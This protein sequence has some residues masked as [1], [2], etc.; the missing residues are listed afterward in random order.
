MKKS[1]VL[2]V[3]VCCGVILCG[4]D[5]K[6]NTDV[7]DISA[8][9]SA[10]ENFAAETSVTEDSVDTGSKITMEDAEQTAF[11]DAG[12]SE[13]DVTHLKVNHDT[14][15]NVFKVEFFDASNEYKYEISSVAGDIISKSI[16]PRLENA[17]PETTATVS[18]PETHPLETTTVQPAVTESTT[19]Q[20]AATTSA[21]AKATAA[22][23]ANSNIN[24]DKA[25]EIAF[26]DAGVSESD[27]EYINAKPD[28]DDGRDVFD[29]EF[30]ADGVEYDYEIDAESG[31]ILS[32]DKDA[33]N[34]KIP[35]KTEKAASG[36]ITEAEAEEIAFR[37]AGVSESDVKRLKTEFDRDDGREIYEVEFYYN[38]M[39]YTYEINAADGSILER[40]VDRD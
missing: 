21:Q 7:T 8:E 15:E 6:G 37:D 33:D 35:A 26:K 9:T 32:F 4:C 12:V 3:L 38:N 14:E 23:V 36:R 13:A 30:Y 10:A 24:A 16:E 31:K 17:V 40:D 20:T 5:N 25:K 28:R 22:T 18:E 29:V 19:Q 27:V 1:V 34:L 2:S 11:A 39:E